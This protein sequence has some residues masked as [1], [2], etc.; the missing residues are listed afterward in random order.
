M[1]E[2][3]NITYKVIV[4]IVIVMVVLSFL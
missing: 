4:I 3:I 2:L 1:L